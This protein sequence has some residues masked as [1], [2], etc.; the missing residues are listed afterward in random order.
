M[1]VI[2]YLINLH[3]GGLAHLD[4]FFVDTYKINCIVNNLKM[5]EQ[6]VKL[7][8]AHLTQYLYIESYGWRPV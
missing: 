7:I 6:V 3:K 8:M 4:F 2:T 5:T 1:F